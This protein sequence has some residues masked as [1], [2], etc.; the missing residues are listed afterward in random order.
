MIAVGSLAR[1]GRQ[2]AKSY[3]WHSAPLEV[4]FDVTYRC[5]AHCSYCTNWTT[6]Y[7]NL[8]LDRI[9][10]LVDRV[11]R[12]GTFQMSLSGGEPLMR[13][14]IVDIVALV[15][16]AGMRCSLVTNGSISRED[17]YQ[18]LMEAGI[19]AIAFSLDG[20]TKESHERFRHGT[21]FERLI[22][23]ISTCMR[24]KEENGYRTRISTNTV[25][26]NAN[27]DEIPGIAALVHS[28]GVKDFKF[29]PVWK[30]HFTSEHLGHS[31]EGH[32]EED[33]P[34]HVP[35]LPIVADEAKVSFNDYY[36][37]TREN[38]ALLARA[39][40]SIREVGSANDPDFTDLIP[41]FYLHTPRARAVTCFAGRAFLFIDADGNVRP[42]GKVEMKFGN[43]LDDQWEADPSAMF[44]TEEARRLKHHAASQECGGCTAVAYMERNMLL[45]AVKH[46]TRLSKIVARRVMR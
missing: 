11:K 19:D 46:P 29:Q 1:L 16:G 23:S 30:Q 25:L 42:C 31:T 7:P 39:V 6:D 45:D 12:L 41:D 15:K 22:R 4:G 38:E 28:L 9:A 27:V 36:G 40:A 24:L 37:F 32:R 13:K 8:P 26:T 35:D 34:R 3:A 33:R 14:D 20:A 2:V 17:L 21:S 44:E 5:N 18:A 10:V 43:I